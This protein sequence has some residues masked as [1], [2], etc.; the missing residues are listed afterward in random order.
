MRS[1][2][3]LTV[4][5][6]MSSSSLSLHCTLGQANKAF[7]ALSYALCGNYRGYKSLT[8]YSIS[9]KCKTKL[10]CSRFSSCVVDDGSNSL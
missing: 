4:E 10:N 8:L 5:D 1:N 2:F 7:L 9:R 3:Q 6:G